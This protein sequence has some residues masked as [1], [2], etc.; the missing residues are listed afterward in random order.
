MEYGGKGHEV[1]MSMAQIWEPWLREMKNVSES[2]SGN[3]IKHSPEIAA[4]LLQWEANSY[5]EFQ[6]DKE[7]HLGLWNH[8]KWA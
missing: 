7:N 5:K 8:S 2:F 4:T 6:S 1:S 3:K